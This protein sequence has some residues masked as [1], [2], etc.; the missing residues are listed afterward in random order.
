MACGSSSRG[1]TP[2]GLDLSA[3]GWRSSAYPGFFSQG[4]PT[5]KGLH[6]F[7]RTLDST[8][9]GL[10]GFF[11][12][13]RVGARCTRSNPGLDDTILSGLSIAAVSLL[14]ASPAEPL[15]VVPRGS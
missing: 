11:C 10:S 5:L 13:P 9:S 7:R 15:Y 8:P 6:R 2:S 3:Q 12:E 1:A 4:V 14:T